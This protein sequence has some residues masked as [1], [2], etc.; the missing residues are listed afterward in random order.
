MTRATLYGSFSLRASKATATATVNTATNPVSND[1]V[2]ARYYNPQGGMLE[3]FS[4]K[5]TPPADA[6]TA[7]RRRASFAEQPN[8]HDSSIAVPRRRVGVSAGL[9]EQPLLATS[10]ATA[11]RETWST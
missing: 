4:K 7:L 11:C 2:E 6:G 10:F 9:R 5:S 3:Q 8:S 1:I